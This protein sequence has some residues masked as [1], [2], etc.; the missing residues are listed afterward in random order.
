MKVKDYRNV[1]FES[2]CERT[3]QYAEFERACKRELKKQCA[4]R[5]INLHSFYG[6]HFEWSAVL[7]RGGKF[8]YVSISDVRYWNWY[9]D[10]LIRT[11][12]H[13]KDWHGGQNNRCSFNEIGEKAV[14]LF[15][16]FE[17]ERRVR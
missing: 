6:S 8:V 7:E 5:G 1:S 14:E 11:M 13:D 15:D 2:S 9:D 4:E 17:R 3:P 10:V 12:E 16:N